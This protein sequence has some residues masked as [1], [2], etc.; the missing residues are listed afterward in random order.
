[1][2]IQIFTGKTKE[3]EVNV[4]NLGLG[5]FIFKNNFNLIIFFLPRKKELLRSQ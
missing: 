4:A 3:D 1:L 2:K 5:F